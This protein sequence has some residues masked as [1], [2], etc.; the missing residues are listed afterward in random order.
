[1]S[2]GITE[3]LHVAPRYNGMIASG[4]T[5]AGAA[6]IA[7]IWI[8][9][10]A[11]SPHRPAITAGITAISAVAASVGATLLIIGAAL[12]VVMRELTKMRNERLKDKR[13]AAV[14]LAAIQKSVD[15]HG[16]NV[17]VDHNA[18][19]RDAL[20]NEEKIGMLIEASA[21]VLAYEEQRAHLRV[22]DHYQIGEVRQQLSGVS[23]DQGARIERLEESAKRVEGQLDI[24]TRGMA[25]L[26]G[27]NVVPLQSVRDL[28]ELNDRKRDK[29]Q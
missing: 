16:H 9:A 18:L 8:T 19:H 29:D 1:M 10:Y 5:T 27:D 23:L 24:L 22:E 15:D 20:K 17:L 21:R 13:A 6:S 26:T 4:I 7:L 12:R 11:A 3:P 28:N 14:K 25:V 2:N